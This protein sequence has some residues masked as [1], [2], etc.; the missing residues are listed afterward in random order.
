MNIFKRNSN[1]I[2]LI[3]FLIFFGSF[4]I[5]LFSSCFPTQIDQIVT[6]ILESVYLQKIFWVYVSVSIVLSRVGQPLHGKIDYFELFVDPILTV[7]TYGLAGSTSLALL[8]GVYL[9]AVHGKPHFYGFSKLDVWSVA[10]VSSFLL[11]YSILKA[12]MELRIFL[13]REKSCA[14]ETNEVDNLNL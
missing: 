8:R 5:A 14:I 1:K 4:S 12:T 9:E 13:L 3:R 10:I 2:V 6:T 7:A 11:F